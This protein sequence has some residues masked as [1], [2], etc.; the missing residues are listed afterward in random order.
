MN[1]HF[2]DKLV[3]R[4]GLE[5]LAAEITDSPALKEVEN[6]AFWQQRGLFPSDALR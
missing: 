2:L 6:V 1:A 4:R 5:E 3:E